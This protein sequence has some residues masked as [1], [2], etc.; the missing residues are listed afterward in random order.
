MKIDTGSITQDA[1]DADALVKDYYKRTIA[2]TNMR[3]L[4]IRWGV[5]KELEHASCCKLFTAR[6]D[7]KLF[8]FSLYIIQNHLHHEGQCVAHCTIIG[9]RPEKRRI[10]IGRLLIEFAEI[11]LKH[12]GV[13][14][15]VHH[16]RAIYRVTP[17]FE[18][19]GFRLEELGYV[20][21]L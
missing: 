2:D 9:V 10:G 12:C 8:G 7:D 14:H 6:E 13:T 3:P 17:L 16:H 15:M 11:R 18:R 1:E 5:Y 20:K 4:R 21:E 19:M